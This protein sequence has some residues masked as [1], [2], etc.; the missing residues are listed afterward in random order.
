MMRFISLYVKAGGKVMAGTDTSSGGA[1]AVS[2][3]GLHHELDLLVHAGLTPMQVLQAATRN[4]AEGFRILDRLG[5][6][7]TGKLAD[8]VVVNEDPLQDINHLQKIEWVIKD[9]KVVDRTFH[10]WFKNPLRNSYGGTVEGRDWVA[11]LK[12]ETALGIRTGSGLKDTSH[13]QGQ[14]CP[15]IE[16]ISPAM[17]TEGDPT[18]TLTI[19]G[20]N[21][22]NKSLVLLDNQPIPARLV[23]ETDETELQ[24]TIDARLIARPETLT[25]TVRN[26][27]LLI[28]PQWGGT[29]N[30]AYLLVNFRY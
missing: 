18:V 27:G 30:R 6:I 22:T 9:G 23:S 29:S 25:I 4:V 14:P 19:R 16:S 1:W 10:P 2:G 8:L 17:V 12:R 11:A 7:E 28:Q 20:V 26:P 13:H 21:F 3:V 15:G 24:A 5:T